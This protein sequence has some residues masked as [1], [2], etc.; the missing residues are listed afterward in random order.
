MGIQQIDAVR[1]S[2][3]I[4]EFINHPGLGAG[5]GNVVIGGMISVAALGVE[6][7]PPT[8]QVLSVY[9]YFKSEEDCPVLCSAFGMFGSADVIKPFGLSEYFSEAN[10]LKLLSFLHRQSGIPNEAPQFM[11][12]YTVATYGQQLLTR[13]A[14][15]GIRLDS[16]A[17]TISNRSDN[18]LRNLIFQKSLDVKFVRYFYGFNKLATSQL[19]VV[20]APVDDR[21]RNILVLP[22]GETAVWLEI[23]RQ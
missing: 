1:A 8:E 21:G 6:N 7:H 4:C 17:H 3:L 15:K 19:R 12:I 5:S 10:E 22:N 11:P 16:Q 18:T 2:R 9:H 23:G 13:F 14:E 20:L